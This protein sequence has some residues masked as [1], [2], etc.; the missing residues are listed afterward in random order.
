MIISMFKD[1]DSLLNKE[2]Y[3]WNERAIQQNG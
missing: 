1:T 3:E 2:G